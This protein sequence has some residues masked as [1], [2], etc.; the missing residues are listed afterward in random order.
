MGNLYVA[1]SIFILKENMFQSAVWSLA[2][3]S[4]RAMEHSVEGKKL[5]TRLSF[6]AHHF[7]QEDLQCMSLLDLCLASCAFQSEVE[8]QAFISIKS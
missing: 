2:F 5:Y 4:Q 7:P 8:P 3:H 1:A 6:K